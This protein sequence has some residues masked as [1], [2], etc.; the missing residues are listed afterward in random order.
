MTAM[1]EPTSG[2]PDQLVLVLAAGKRQQPVQ[3]SF[4]DTS[5]AFKDS[6]RGACLCYSITLSHFLTHTCPIDSP[7]VHVPLSHVLSVAISDS[8]VDAHVLEK[9]HSGLNLVKLSGSLQGDN[10]EASSTANEWVQGAMNA[11]YSGAWG[12]MH[13]AYHK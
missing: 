8:V 5:F 4:N 11:A 3:F 12:S 7:D 10:A 9:S 6:S 1:A 2:Y 13:T